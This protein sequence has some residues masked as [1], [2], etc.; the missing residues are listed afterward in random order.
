[1]K[2]LVAGG[3]IAGFGLAMLCDSVVLHQILQWHHSVSILSPI[4]DGDAGRVSLL[5]DGIFDLAACVVTGVGFMLLVTEH[6]AEA[7]Y[8]RDLAR[9]ALAG[10]GTAVVLD[11]SVNHL[12]LGIHHVR[13]GAANG[14]AYDV[15]YL[16]F[17][18][19]FPLLAALVLWAAGP[20]T[21]RSPSPESAC[22][23]PLR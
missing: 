12:L 3:M 10:W 2:R 21:M 14:L 16:V 13:A 8:R 9:W 1:M 22:C 19:I 11:G 20:G 15:G 23:A 4:P 6:A 5:A 17:A 7:W 18:G